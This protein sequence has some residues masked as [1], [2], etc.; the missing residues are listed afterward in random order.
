MKFLHSHLPLENHHQRHLASSLSRHKH[1]LHLLFVINLHLQC[2]INLP[3]SMTNLHPF[4]INHLHL[5]LQPVIQVLHLFIVIVIRIVGVHLA[6]RANLVP[7][8]CKG[9]NLN[10]PIYPGQLIIQEM[11]EGLQRPLVLEKETLKEVQVTIQ[12]VALV[13]IGE[14]VI[15]I[16]IEMEII[17]E[18]TEMMII[19]EE[20]ITE[21]IKG[22]IIEGVTIG[23][24]PDGIEVIG[25]EAV[26]GLAIEVS[27]EIMTGAQIVAGIVA[28]IE[29]GIVIRKEAIMIQTGIQEVGIVVGIEAGIGLVIAAGI[30]T[31]KEAIMI[32]TEIVK[33]IVRLQAATA[34]TATIPKLKP[35]RR[36]NSFLLQK[37]LKS[38]CKLQGHLHQIQI[39]QLTSLD[40]LAL[41]NQ[42]RRE[43]MTSFHFDRGLNRLFSEF[44]H[45]FSTYFCKHFFLCLF[46][47]H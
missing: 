41:G 18:I 44:I 42:N 6:P 32:Q 22:I 4:T 30:L 7:L 19:A 5:L 31:R 45:I 35:P 37:G 13:V 29:A 23:L 43:T 10:N 40:L 8:G 2:M 14:V 28:G 27:K 20:V 11:K 25:I 15:E 1:L 39:K 24:M 46:P 26:T 34:Y 16:V 17:I 47:L 33:E 36:F 9:L 21:G 12:I 38:Q 3:L